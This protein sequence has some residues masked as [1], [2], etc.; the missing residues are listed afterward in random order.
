M[1]TNP[2][3]EGGGPLRW[4]A[5]N[6]G[7]S[8][9]VLVCWT[10]PLL[11]C[12]VTCLPDAYNIVSV[13]VGCGILLSYMGK[14]NHERADAQNRDQQA[15][16]QARLFK[17][18]SAPA[19]TFETEPRRGKDTLPSRG[20][21]HAPLK[22]GGGDAYA[23]VALQDQVAKD[24]AKNPSQLPVVPGRLRRGRQAGRPSTANKP[25]SAGATVHMGD[26]SRDRGYARARPFTLGDEMVGDL[27]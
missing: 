6:C 11:A 15:V 18:L 13:S 10:V 22:P 4:I 12:S 24:I 23:P 2:L 14:M 21:G 8:I 20:A 27:V 5:S 26:D 25:H 16:L 1:N 7:V 17:E 19:E 3:S 9:V